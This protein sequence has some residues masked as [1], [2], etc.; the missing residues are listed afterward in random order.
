MVQL[1]GVARATEVT[2]V[3][4][5]SAIEEDNLKPEVTMIWPRVNAEKL[6]NS[7]PV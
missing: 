3:A 7:L 4:N 2:K 1:A 6:K 5:A